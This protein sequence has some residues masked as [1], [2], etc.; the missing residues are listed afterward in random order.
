MSHMGSCYHCNLTIPPDTVISGKVLGE[1]RAFSSAGCAANQLSPGR[2]VTTLAHTGPHAMFSFE[3]ALRQG[4]AGSLN[5]LQKMDFHKVA[6]LSGDNAEAMQILA[7]KLGIS[8]A[9]GGLSPTE[10]LAWVQEQQANGVRV[11]VVGDGINDAPV[12]TTADAAMSFS[13][14]TELAR[15]SAD[16]VILGPDFKNLTKD[17]RLASATGRISRQNLLWAAAIGMSIRSLLVVFN[18]MQLKA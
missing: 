12:M 11:V 15:Q 2:S 14:A 7:E 16:F 1:R 8:E 18:A 4:V 3:D 6:I 10:K 5:E 9:H 13:G 17:F